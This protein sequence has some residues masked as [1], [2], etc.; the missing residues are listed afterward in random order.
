MKVKLSKRTCPWCAV[1][2]VYAVTEERLTIALADHLKE[3]AGG[4]WGHA[5]RTG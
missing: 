5:E 3:C 1:T 4:A 2:H